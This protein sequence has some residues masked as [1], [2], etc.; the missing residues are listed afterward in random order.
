MAT[1]GESAP[2][3]GRYIVF[4]GGEGAGKSTQARLLAGRL[5]A[6]LTR[7]PGGTA[8]GARLRSLLL[9]PDAVPV[10]HRSE[11]LMMAAD[12]AQ[13]LEE[14]VRPAVGAGRHVVSDRS[15]YSSLAYQG[16][17]RDLGVDEITRLNEWA[18]GGFW[19]DVVVLLDIDPLH[20]TDRLKGSLDR[21][22]REGPRFHQTVAQTFRRLAES[23]PERWIVLDA[24]GE[25]EELANLV[26]T[27]VCEQLPGLDQAC[28]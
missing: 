27:R 9:D 28:R 20:A 22:E 1:P 21:L 14:V 8:L 25:V 5:G 7:E 12:R 23:D 3:R 6:V 26:A 16:G 19:P 2:R 4:E 15:V 18:M 13:H 11:A 10:S 17:G 24:R